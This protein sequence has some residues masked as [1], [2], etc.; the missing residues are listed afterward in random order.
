MSSLILPPYRGVTITE[1]HQLIL[2]AMLPSS[3]LDS[4]MFSY[5]TQLKDLPQIV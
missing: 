5:V 4:L 3:T 2:T 1:L